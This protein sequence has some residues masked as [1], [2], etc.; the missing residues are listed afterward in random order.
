MNRERRGKGEGACD[1]WGGGV[2][3]EECVII[4]GG[5]GSEGGGVCDHWGGVKG[6]GM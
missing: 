2:K 3:G 6:R 4:G 5:G 1:H